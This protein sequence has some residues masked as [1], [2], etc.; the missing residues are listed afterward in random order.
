M[1]SDDTS[2]WVC[3]ECSLPEERGLMLRR[4]CHHCGKVLCNGCT[5]YVDDEAF[6]RRLLG[7]RR[8]I[9][10]CSS[11]RNRYHSGSRPL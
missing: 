8:R 7:S 2:P 9:V 4:A 11:C 6:A 1:I 10:H 3:G 5:K